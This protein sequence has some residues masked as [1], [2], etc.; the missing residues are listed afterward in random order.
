MEYG[1]KRIGIFYF[2]GTGNTRIVAEQIG[3]EFSGNSIDVILIDI[4]DFLQDQNSVDIKLF[5]LVG[6]GF[7]IYGLGAPRIVIDFINV[8]VIN[9][10]SKVFLF[11]TAADFFWV[12]KSASSYPVK[13]LKKKG[14]MVFYDRIIVMPSNWLVAYNDRFVKQLYNVSYKKS[15]HMVKEIKTGKKRVGKPNAFLKMISGFI[16]FFESRFGSRFFGISLAV[17]SDCNDCKFCYTSCPANN[18]VRVND[19]IQF[20]NNCLWCMRCVYSCKKKAIFSRGF[21][22]TIIKKGYNLRKIVDDPLIKGDSINK[23]TKGFM[24]HFYKYLNDDRI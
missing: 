24:G 7:P 20:G 17:N 22:F 10:G 14:C 9:P 5:D 16:H 12:N 8:M 19:K 11:Q 18:I 6:I 1:F 3:D 2:S 4:A 23:D 13:K 21:S 15:R